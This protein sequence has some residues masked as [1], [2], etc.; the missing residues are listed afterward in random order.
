MV[1][2]ERGLRLF[3]PTAKPRLPQSQ[4][5]LPLPEGRAPPSAAV[6]GPL[7]VAAGGHRHR[8]ETHINIFLL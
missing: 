6:F 2:T 7:V 1:E 4:T 8:A 5:G 3:T